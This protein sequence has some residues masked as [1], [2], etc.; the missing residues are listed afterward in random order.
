MH[1]GHSIVFNVIKCFKMVRPGFYACVDL[2]CTY[3]YRGLKINNNK[4]IKRVS[5]SQMEN[6]YI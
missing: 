5:L 1:G 4:H 2:F 3:L 6:I